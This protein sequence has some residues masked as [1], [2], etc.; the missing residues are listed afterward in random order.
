MMFVHISYIKIVVFEMI[1]RNYI[2]YCRKE[3]CLKKACIIKNNSEALQQNT[4]RRKV[5]N[6]CT[7]LK[8][9]CAHLKN[10]CIF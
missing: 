7:H 9:T 6:T 10:T 3:R 8:N 4:C 1:Y 5:E 2:L